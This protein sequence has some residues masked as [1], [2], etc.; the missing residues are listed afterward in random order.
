MPTLFFRNTVATV[1]GNWLMSETQGSATDN[2]ATTH[3]G[4]GTANT[5]Q[6]LKPGASQGTTTTTTLSTTAPPATTNQFGWFTDVAYNGTFAAATWTASMRQDDTTNSNGFPN[7]NVFKCSQQG[8]GGTWTFLFTITGATSWWNNSTST[9]S[10][11]ASPGSITL[12]NEYMF[13]QVWC[14]ETTA[15]SAKTHHFHV[16]G[17]TS[18]S[19]IVTPTFTPAT[20]I[21]R[22]QTAQA[23]ST[24]GATS[25]TATL[26]TTTLA[27]NLLVALVTN[28][29]ATSITSFTASNST[30]LTQAVALNTAAFAAIYY[31]PNCP[32]GLTS[33]TLTLPFNDCS[34]Q[35]TEY[36]GCATTS[37]LDKTSSHDS[38]FSPGS[39]SWTS[40]AT[41]TLSQ[42]G[43]LIVGGATEWRAITT[44]LSAGTGFNSVMVSSD[45]KNIFEDILNNAT[46]TGIAA[47]GTASNVTSGQIYALAAT[48]LTTASAPAPRAFMMTGVG[49]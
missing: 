38:G 25:L 37:P 41:A 13:F 28:S 36:S 33:V 29:G 11:T 9:V 3:T 43:E 8:F 16:N 26:P 34:I 24:T 32:S 6:I 7:I 14:N 22:R 1:A 27:G 49:N 45:G 40:N 17:T 18:Q 42:S 2:T 44:A 46:T 20:G 10:A 30:A 12:N 48:F 4:N 23:L 35:I 31:Y 5:F 21:S 15:I 19:Q 39:T 47:T